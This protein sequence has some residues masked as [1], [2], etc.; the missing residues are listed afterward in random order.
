MKIL[1]VCL[2]NI[3]R[4]PTAHGILQKMVTEAGLSKRIEIDSAGTSAYHAGSLPDERMIKTARQ[5]AYDLTFI[6]SR[7]VLQSD[8]AEFDLILAMDEHNFEDLQSICP[9]EYLYKLKLFLEYHP[10]TDKVSVPDP[11]YGGEAGFDEVVK[12]VEAS[13]QNLMTELA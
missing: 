3:C 11:Y 6:R 9:D 4:S 5:Y 10:N 12:L 7:K 8:F 13:C 1:F 2:G